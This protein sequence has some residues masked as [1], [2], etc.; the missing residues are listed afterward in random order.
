MSF[1]KRV[2]G[3]FTFLPKKNVEFSEKGGISKKLAQQG[4]QVGRFCE[5]IENNSVYVTG[6]PEMFPDVVKLFEQEIKRPVVNIVI[7]KNFSEA[8]FNQ[9]LEDF[10]EQNKKEIGEIAIPRDKDGNVDLR[11]LVKLKD[12]G[13]AVEVKG[14]VVNIEGDSDKEFLGSTCQFIRGLSSGQVNEIRQIKLLV[15]VGSKAELDQAERTHILIHEL[16]ENSTTV[17]NELRR[18]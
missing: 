2:E 15:L 7:D 1:F 12:L 10:V 14:D 13:I 9:V 8:S 5:S 4:F 18:K 17:N 16:V 3:K 6:R 11:D